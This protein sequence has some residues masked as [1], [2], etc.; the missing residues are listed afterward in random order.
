MFQGYSGYAQQI[1]VGSG[2]YPPM[3]APNF[4]PRSVNPGQ[5][6]MYGEQVAGRVAGA[7]TGIANFGMSMMQPGGLAGMGLSMLGV[8]MPLAAAGG[9]AISAGLAGGSMLAGGLVSGG[10]ALPLMAAQQAVRAYGTAFTGGMQDQAS[11]NSTL[12]SNF[13]FM[14]GQGAYGR[15]F[16]QNQMGQVGAMISGE[17]RRNP[18]TSAGELNE[19]ISGGAQSGMFTG[20]RDVQQF[21]QNFRKML[22]TLK[23]VQRELGGTLTDALQFVRSSQQAGIFQNADRANFASEIR[24][25]EAVT[26][27]DRN[28]LVALSAQGANISR[29]FGGQGRQGAFGAMRLA[30][31]LGTAMQ[32][33]EMTGVSPELLS[34]VTG[35]LTGADAIS[36]TVS[37]MMSR[38]GRFS[39]RAMGRFSTFA[40]SNSTGTGLDQGMMD[41][42]L[43]G[44]ISVG[45]VRGAAHRN[46]RGMGR[47][48]AINR[49]GELAG[50]IMEQG[51]LAG[52]IGMMRLMVGERVLDADDDLGQ[53][54][55]Q[56]RM[57]MSRPESQL[58]MNLMRN[59]RHIA[60][61][62]RVA[63]VTSGRETENRLYRE[64]NNTMDAFTRVL[65]HGLSDMSGL[66]ATREMGRRFMTRISSGIERAMNN[67][68]GVV[69]EGLSGRD[70]T[71]FARSAMGIATERDRG[72]MARA[73]MSGGGEALASTRALDQQSMGMGMLH[74]LGIHTPMTPAETLARQGIDSSTM[75]MPE[76]MRSALVNNAARQGIV[77]GVDRTRLESLMA[78]RSDTISRI[79]DAQIRARG[80]GDASNFL[81]LMGEGST[82]A[83]LA[84]M[85]NERMATP[86]GVN[87]ASL[88]RRLPTESMLDSLTGNNPTDNAF[89]FIARGGHLASR[90]ERETAGIRRGGSAA[91][92]EEIR[93]GLLERSGSSA[94]TIER[95]ESRTA[96]G[97]A[98]VHRLEGLRGVSEENLRAVF[99]HEEFAESVTRASELSGDA[100]RAH[101]TTMR[102]DAL[103]MTDEGQRGAALSS[104]AQMEENARSRG[105]RRGSLGSEFVRA[106][107]AAG[108]GEREMAARAEA[109]RAGATF[110]IM[111]GALRELEGGGDLSRRLADISERTSGAYSNLAMSTFENQDQARE[112]V[113]A[114]SGGANEMM[115]ELAHADP[116]SEEYR[117]IASSLAAREG[118]SDLLRGA[119]ARRASEREIRGEGRRGRAGAVDRLLGAATGNTFSSMH[120]RIGNRDISASAAR[121][122]L[123]AGGEGSSDIME[124]MTTQLSEAGM[125]PEAARRQMSEVAGLLESVGRRGGTS[126]T[127]VNR[128][129]GLETTEGMEAVRS[130]AA[131]ASREAALSR[132]PVG[133]EQLRVLESIRDRLPE[134]PARR[135]EAEAAA[136]AAGT[137][138]AEATSSSGISGLL[139]SLVPGSGE[140]D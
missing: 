42:F 128:A 112:A 4:T 19:L 50:N 38:A 3:P 28:Q 49:E 138:A 58:M 25:A 81:S 79:A 103:R 74:S 135:A 87:M 124:Q 132:D 44:D 80:R 65:E 94:S 40:M 126:E 20:V 14:G 98:D 61:Q 133:A 1:G 15:G 86:E 8:P 130:R 47:A 95:S 11:L 69:E 109:A 137:A 76:V 114:A 121:R 134:A 89:A 119:A 48:R 113:N 66:T 59:Q 125:S 56:R 85:A 57:G 9:G 32:N 10:L 52:Q 92:D 99:G 24:T 21:T 36:A 68:L 91:G 122:M 72:Q 116:N 108:G 97:L 29:A 12:R 96:E 107:G 35:G 88:G 33:P 43:A 63:N 22:D 129:L 39:R 110:N 27:M 84:F 6:G 62:E 111:G 67:F 78:N 131:E 53:L 83:T 115:L 140:A 2:L 77:T 104:I 71:A 139:S 90:L 82:N 120:F 26:G 106:A 54:V 45:D 30:Q 37:G 73:L 16:S 51:G 46:V 123:M 55:L 13:N 41:R 34:E 100:L 127:D 117:R 70:R 31:T 105:F 5:G 17:L 136:R 23:S 7:A 102:A 93:R 18:F 101:F 60:E 64:Q 118:G 75:T